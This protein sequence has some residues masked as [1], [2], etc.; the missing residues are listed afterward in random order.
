MEFELYSHLNNY[1]LHSTLTTLETTQLDINQK[2]SERLASKD[3]DWPELHTTTM[4]GFIHNPQRFGFDGFDD[5]RKM[6]CEVKS[7]SK[8]INKELLRKFVS[9]QL[10][11]RNQFVGNPI[12]GRGIFSLFTHDAYFRYS[13][14]N[15]QMLISAYVN[16]VLMFII[17]FPFSHPTFDR[18]IKRMLGEPRTD[19]DKHPRAKTISFGYSQYKDCKYAKLLYLTTD[20]NLKVLKGTCSK[21]FYSY[22]MSLR[23]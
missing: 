8:I 20:E 10:S 4:A 11:Q 14:E 7:S 1:S 15:V 3:T 9:G 18:H 19:G 16:G 23:K 2:K 6:Y 17:E 21:H 5:V 22:L 12:D 13:T